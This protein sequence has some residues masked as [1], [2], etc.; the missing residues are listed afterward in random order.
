MGWRMISRS[1]G[2]VSLLVL[3]RL[4]A[5]ADFGIVALAT[6]VTA[7]IDSL[8]QLGVRD[9]LVRLKEG[10]R[11]YYDAAFT[12]QVIRGLITGG[13]IAGLSL[14]SYGLLNEP[15]LQG[16]LLV[17]AAVAVISSFEN[18]GVVG[19]SREMDFRMQFVLQALP[20]L[21]GFVVTTVLAFLLHSYWALV[22]GAAV[23]KLFAV[24]LSY[25]LSA[26]RPSF[27]LLGWRYLLSFSF[28]SWSNGIAMLIW[29]RADPFLLG[30]V[31]GSEALGLFMVA[32]EIAMLPVSELIDP[33]SA[34]LFP[35][36]SLAQ[37]S[38]TDPLDIGLTI[39]GVLALCAAPFALGVSACS[40]LLV[41]ALLGSKWEAA[42]PI[43]AIMA[44]LCLFSPFSYVCSSVLSAKGMV[45]RVFMGT[46]AA[47]A[48]KVAAILLVR[49]T[50]DL[51]FISLTV[52]VVVAAE[53]SIF[54]W[55]LRAA[56]NREFRL[57][58][59]S[60]LRVV[61]ALAGSGAVLYVMPMTWQVVKLGQF[62]AV[63]VGAGIGL[64]TF[65]LFF[66]LQGG[67]WF[68][69]GRPAGPEARLLEALHT[70]GLLRLLQGALPRR[71][72]PS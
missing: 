13:L 15:R 53:S 39:A 2:F 70:S 18:I 45:T 55:Q 32:G 1:L 66:A 21:V 65:V 30:P 14:L 64:L 7:A 49:S 43:V 62:A 47:A 19:F 46:A 67:L 71:L 34:A 72:R 12:F 59:A 36:F 23:A 5:P 37:R 3:A 6:S 8:S 51:R 17:L 54:I 42:Q 10:H 48:M 44:W 22:W 33:A 56:G 27:S 28:W 20:R 38:G 69:V 29:S 24:L 41:A 35:G 9:A 63:L 60:M 26:H 11:D 57:L 25:A 40:G 61:V 31:L 4:L 52:V 50:G 58:V 68:I 16:V